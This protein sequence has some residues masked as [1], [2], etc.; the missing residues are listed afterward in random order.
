MW[1]RKPDVSR[2]SFLK[3]G[4]LGAAA[5]GI[6]PSVWAAESNEKQIDSKKILNYNSEMRYRPLPGTDISLS[7]ISLGGLVNVPA[8][9]D[10]AIDRGVNLVHI[11]TSYM[12]GS[13]LVDLG[14]VLKTKRDKVY[15]AL[16]DNFLPQEFKSADED[17]KRFKEE[18][19]FEKLNTDYVDFFMFNRHE[20]NEP[21]DPQIQERFE[22]LKA[23]GIVRY[24]GLTI[25]GDVPGTVAAGIKNNVFKLI[26]P[27]FNQPNLEGLDESLKKM[28]ENGMR[29]MAMKTMGGFGV[30][31]LRRKDEFKEKQDEE[32]QKI[33]LDLQCAYLK[34][35]LSNPSV[36][37]INKGIGTFDMFDAFAKAAREQLTLSEDRALYRYAQAN[38]SENCMMCDECYQACPDNIRIS[39]IIRCKDYYHDQFGDRN[40][41]LAY[42]HEIPAAQ[43]LSSRCGDC[44]ICEETCPNGLKIVERLQAAHVMFA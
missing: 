5:A 33:S 24:A 42:Y 16:K 34:K 13:S 37:T 11:S 26:M 21:L 17:I 6:S 22:A 29:I 32:L 4:M 40:T 1:N 28:Q 10:Y 36:I 23:K 15:I 44:S 30:K 39:T 2:R 9:N 3:G 20:A 43:R 41:A 27:T 14:K 38:R 18:G 12:G 19:I 35:A 31:D 25:H 8:V 7:V